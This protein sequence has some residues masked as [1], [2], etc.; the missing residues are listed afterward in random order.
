MVQDMGLCQRM[1][2]GNTLEFLGVRTALLLFL[3]TATRKTPKDGNWQYTRISS[4]YATSKTP[5]MKMQDEQD[6]KNENARNRI[7]KKKTVF[8]CLH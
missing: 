2:I 4:E 1:A 5:K 3:L 6:T 8:Q 7:S